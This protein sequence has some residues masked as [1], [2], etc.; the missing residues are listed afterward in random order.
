M[1]CSYFGDIWRLSETW[2][3]YRKPDYFYHQRS[4][5]YT[6]E[7][8]MVKSF[9][10]SQ[11]AKAITIWNAANATNIENVTINPPMLTH[12]PELDLRNEAYLLEW[13][14]EENSYISLSP[15]SQKTRL[16]I[17]KNWD[18]RHCC[19]V[20]FCLQSFIWSDKKARFRCC[21][22]PLQKNYGNSTNATTNSSERQ[23][24]TDEWKIQIPE[25]LLERKNWT[26]GSKRVWPSS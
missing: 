2:D 13:T 8:S 10:P 14:D 11:A 21:R 22:Y 7:T 17:Y 6:K 15:V 18:K 20:S 12:R 9:A 16:N 23:F 4:D 24:A 1:S 26:R 5:R 25:L 19:A 3:I